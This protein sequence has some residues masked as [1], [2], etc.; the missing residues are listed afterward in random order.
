MAL[1]SIIASPAM[2]FLFSQAQSMRFI[3]HQLV[4]LKLLP[5]SPFVFP[6][7]FGI[8]TASAWRYQY[9]MSVF[10]CFFIV[11]LSTEIYSFLITH[12]LQK[13]LH[14]Y[15]HDQ[16]IEIFSSLHS[17]TDLYFISN[18]IIFSKCTY[19]HLPIILIIVSFDM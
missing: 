15:L 3:N 16:Y 19:I 8:I 11:V 2:F 1:I 14:I 5:E 13:H 12:S 18:Q 9:W 7:C 6:I 17:L 4:F 10:V